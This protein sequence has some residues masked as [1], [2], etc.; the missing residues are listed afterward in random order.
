MRSLLLLYGSPSRKP[1]AGKDV[2]GDIKAR[3]QSSSERHGR[4]AR[5]VA[6]QRREH[7]DHS[8]DRELRGVVDLPERVLDVIAPP[9]DGGGLDRVRSIGPRTLTAVGRRRPRSGV[10]PAQKAWMYASAATAR[11]RCTHTA[12]QPVPHQTLCIGLC[13]RRQSQK[14]NCENPTWRYAC[15]ETI[16]ACCTSGGDSTFDAIRMAIAGTLWLPPIA[17]DTK[18][19]S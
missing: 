8:G 13:N 18:I 7:G 3:V 6:Y 11:S 9:V 17:P 16:N 1:T 15:H 19:T 10:T 5:R 14:T 12:S 4:C 2:G